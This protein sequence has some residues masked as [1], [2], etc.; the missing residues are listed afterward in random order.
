MKTYP[1]FAEAG[2]RLLAM[3]L[4]V[5]GTIGSSIAQ[6]VSEPSESGLFV[7]DELLDNLPGFDAFSSIPKYSF[8]GGFTLVENSRRGHLNVTLTIRPHYHGYSQK[9]RTGQMPTRITVAESDQYKVIGPFAPDVDPVLTK[10]ISGNEVEVFEGVVTWSAPIELATDVDPASL[11]I[12]VRVDGQVC[13]DREGCT[14][15]DARKSTVQAG[16]DGYEPADEA[17]SGQTEYHS[18]HDHLTIRGRV[19]NPV[20]QSGETVQVEIT[21][22]PARHWHVYHF[23][24]AR[25]KGASSVPTMI[26]FTRRGEWKIES[27]PRASSEP[28][29]QETGLEDEPILYFHERP[30]TW[31]I[32]LT[33]PEDAEPG[34]QTLDG[35]MVFQVCRQET[36][37]RPEV[38]DF[39]VPVTIVETSPPQTPPT[40]ELRFDKSERT[41]AEANQG[42]SRF[43]NQA[44]PKKAVAKAIS[45]I[46]LVTYLG[47]AFLAGLILNAMPCVLP[48][49]GLK[50]MSFVQQAGESRFRIFLLNFTFALGLMTVFWV[51]A[52]LAAFFGMGWGDW[53]TRSMVGSII[54][55]SVVF[56]FGLSMLGIWEIPI[57]GI[58]GGVGGQGQEEGLSGAYALGIFTTILATPCTGPLLVPATTIIAGQPAWMAYLIFTFLGLGMASPYLIIGMFPSLIGW[59]PRPGGWMNTFKQITG[60]VLMG[61]VVFLLAAFTEEPWSEY[62][63]AVLTLLLAIA[64]GCWWIGRTSIAAERTRQLRAWGQGLTMIAV[65]A[66]F[67]FTMLVPSEYE[68]DWQEYSTVKLNELRAKSRIVFIDFTGPN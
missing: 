48:V 23:Q 27:L 18:E 9:K 30:V 29:T 49:I 58:S 50:V 28:S 56:A 57:P 64:L 37:D 6:E 53:L 40:A 19:V 12:E 41:V 60:F 33:A 21:A 54:I 24:P 34:T 26:Y 8:D 31:T 55:T 14:Q 46:E 51:L 44:L 1:G 52:T 22:V 4:L 13:H 67:A 38:L 32:E 11:E 43:W 5:L 36:C 39:T 62:M 16:F 63:I 20:V 35:V 47:M 65:G 66:A 2:F 17:A 61:T 15:F 7:Q 42:A 25:P 59:L 3:L 10:D 68:L 45:G